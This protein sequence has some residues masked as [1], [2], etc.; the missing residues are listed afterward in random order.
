MLNDNESTIE[1]FIKVYLNAEK[2]LS[3]KIELSK[4]YLKGYYKQAD[5]TKNKLRAV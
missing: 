5:E 2:A 4:N 1:E 3:Q